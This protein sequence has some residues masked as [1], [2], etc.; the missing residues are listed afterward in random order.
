MYI[1]LCLC[2]YVCRD[3]CIMYVCRCVCITY[4]YRSVC[5][6]MHTFETGSYCVVLY[7]LELTHYVDYTGLKF[8]GIL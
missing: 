2:V 5:V 3:V 4:V 8:T 6:Y 7:V 1:D